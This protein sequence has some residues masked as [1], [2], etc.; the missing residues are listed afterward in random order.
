LVVRINAIT[1]EQIG[2]FERISIPFKPEVNIICGEN[3]IGKTTIIEAVGTV[4]AGHYS[5]IIKNVSSD[6]GAIDFSIQVEGRDQTGRLAIERSMP[7]QGE[8]ARVG[9]GL[10]RLAK[11]VLYIKA[12]RDIGYRPLGSLHRD[13]D[14]LPNSFNA[15]LSGGM[16]NEDLKNWFVNRALF[17]GQPN[18]LSDIE[19][20]DLKFAKDSLSFLDSRIRYEGVRGRDFQ[21]L[22]KTPDGTIPFEF[23]SSGHRTTFYTIL[24]VIKEVEYRRLD[25]PAQEFAGLILID[26]IDLHLHPDWQ[27]KIVR[28]LQ[29]AFP[30]AQFIVTTHSPH[31]I[32]A[33]EPGDVIALIRNESGAVEPQSLPKLKYGFQGWT[34]EEILQDIMGVKSANSELYDRTLMD[35]NDALEREDQQKIRYSLDILLEMLHPKNP[36]RRLLQLQAGPYLG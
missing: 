14:R 30:K 9:N 34:I 23:L 1:L 26:E 2:C 20:T 12:A 3:G 32:Q 29:V 19:L 11:E 17:E 21:I 25:Y 28:I 24:G 7:D 22:I 15:A 35:F 16:S 31:V 13:P 27:R 10:L 18:G 8:G 6:R 33:A 5:K 4:F 36:M